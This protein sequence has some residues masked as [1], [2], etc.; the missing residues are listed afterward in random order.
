MPDAPLRSRR[1]DGAGASEKRHSVQDPLLKLLHIEIDDRCNE[2]RDELL[3]DQ[4]ADD[5]QTEGPARSAIGAEAKRDR[6]RAEHGRQRGH[7]YRP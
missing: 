5:N 7:E 3:H 2:Q 1:R 4:T 6:N